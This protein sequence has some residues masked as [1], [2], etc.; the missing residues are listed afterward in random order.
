[1]PAA[2]TKIITVLQNEDLRTSKQQQDQQASPSGTYQLE[3]L[4]LKELLGLTLSVSHAQHAAYWME[5]L[6]Q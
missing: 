6:I 3:T 4:N 5:N 2:T 1:M